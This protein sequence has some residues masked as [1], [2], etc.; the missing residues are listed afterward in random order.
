[1]SCDGNCATCP[2]QCGASTLSKLEANKKE[3]RTMSEAVGGC[4]AGNEE[5]IGRL[6]ERSQF[7]TERNNV[8]KTISIVAFVVAIIALFIAWTALRDNAATQKELSEFKA[9][10]DRIIEKADDAERAYTNARKS[11]E[12]A[13]DEFRS[14]K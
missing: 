8:S 3:T 5:K 6:D 9:N 2:I 13:R 11:L 1:M 7:A 12:R 10:T 4:H 14:S